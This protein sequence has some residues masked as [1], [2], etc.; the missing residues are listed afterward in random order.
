MQILT[1]DLCGRVRTVRN[2]HTDESTIEVQQFSL[3]CY[4]HGGRAVIY[5]NLDVC[6]PCEDAVVMAIRAILKAKAKVTM[7][8]AK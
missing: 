7:G 3:S 6:K 1:C 4:G 5:E 8:G 2:G